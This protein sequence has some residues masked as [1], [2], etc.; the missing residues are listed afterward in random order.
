[1]TIKEWPYTHNKDSLYNFAAFAPKV[2]VCFW[3]ELALLHSQF[4]RLLEKNAEQFFSPKVKVCFWIELALLH[5][6]FKRL[7]EKNAEQFF[8][9]VTPCSDS[10]SFFS[11]KLV[12]SRFRFGQLFLLFLITCPKS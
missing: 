5:S 11:S 12:R 9:E 10:F 6:Q 4:K 2:K 7:L 1:M 8:S 3:I